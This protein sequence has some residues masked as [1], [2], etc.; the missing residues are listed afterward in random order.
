MGI[1]ETMKRTAHP[2]YALYYKD[3]L[4]SYLSLNKLINI[5]RNYVPF[6]LKE[7]GLTLTPSEIGIMSNP[8][9]LNNFME[10]IKVFIN[11][12]IPLTYVL[13]SFHKNHYLIF[14]GAQ[15]LRLD[16]ES[17]DFPHVKIGRASCRER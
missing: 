11:R 5:L 16:A 13:D 12:V 8:E 4:H 2:E 6:R 3:L 1:N 9:L 14:E 17:H 7:L 10:D 15:G